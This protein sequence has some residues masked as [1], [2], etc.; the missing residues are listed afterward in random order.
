M[1]SHNAN[2][3]F[4]R[5]SKKVSQPSQTAPKIQVV[6]QERKSASWTIKNPHAAGID[7]GS[8]RHF[9]AVPPDSVAENESFVRDFGPF[10]D[11]LQKWSSG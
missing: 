7:L 10:T 8:R 6:S 5:S 2:N 1:R 4:M 3:L 9:V 11:E